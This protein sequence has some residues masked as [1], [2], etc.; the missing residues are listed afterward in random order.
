MNSLTQ[1]APPTVPL[2]EALKDKTFFLSDTNPAANRDQKE[3]EQL[4]LKVMDTPEIAQARKGAEFQWLSV[5]PKEIREQNMSLFDDMITEYLFANVLK[6]VNSDANYPKVICN[7]YGPP[8]EWFGMNV[9]GCRIGGDCPDNYYAAI[10]IDPNA[11]TEI[12]GEQIA[13]VPADFNANLFAAVSFRTTLE[14]ITGVNL[15]VN[16]DGSFVIT[17]DPEPANGR[18]NHIQTRPNGTWLFIRQT[19]GDWNQ[20]PRT[21]RV[22]RLDPPSAPPISFEEIVRRAV[23]YIADDVPNTYWWMAMSLAIPA[24]QST[25][26]FSTKTVGGLVSQSAGFGHVILENDEALIVTVG[27]GGA[28]FRDIVLLDYWYRSIHYDNHTSSFTD[29]QGQDNGDGTTTYVVSLKDPGVYNW[30]DPVGLHQTHLVFRWQLLP[31]DLPKG[32]VEPFIKTELVQ[33]DELEKRLSSAVPRITQSERQQ[34]IA[35]RK[36]AYQ[37]RYVDC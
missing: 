36:E 19:R 4:A 8:H 22:R 7:L 17:L 26:P 31:L 35:T 32:E 9:P 15:V 1:N 29:R 6:A 14:I 27:H 30:L 21:L 28:G 13:P 11:R 20:V 24:N 5:T 23:E 37:R 10:P 34:Q 2:S 18:P 33:L 16:D 12:Y 25:G 3:L